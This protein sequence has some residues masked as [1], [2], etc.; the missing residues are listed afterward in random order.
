MRVVA[1]FYHVNVFTRLSEYT[2]HINTLMNTHPHTHPCTQ[3]ISKNDL[4]ASKYRVL[5]KYFDDFSQNIQT[6]LIF[7]Y[8]IQLRTLC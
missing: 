6:K 4:R 7:E 3:K 5:M 2:T 1:G 8:N